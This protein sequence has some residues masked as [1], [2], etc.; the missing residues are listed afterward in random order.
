MFLIFS[1]FVSNII[2]VHII[3]RL[4]S[5]AEVCVITQY[6]Q[7]IQAACKIYSSLLHDIWCGCLRSIVEIWYASLL[8][9]L[10]SSGVCVCL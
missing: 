8:I 6:H 2:F 10:S 4:A 7:L 9:T 5:L 3:Y 1:I